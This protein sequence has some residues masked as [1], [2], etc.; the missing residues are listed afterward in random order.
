MS[1]RA[2]ELRVLRLV[3]G[4][5]KAPTYQAIA[6]ALRDE[7]QGEGGILRRILS[8]WEPRLEAALANLE[9]QGCL[10]AT[11]GGGIDMPRSEARERRVFKLTDAGQL[12]L[13]D[14]E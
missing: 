13:K 10:H 3:A 11:T 1:L 14:N 4:L 5:G 12:V 8:L 9:D 2:Y 6:D 7:K